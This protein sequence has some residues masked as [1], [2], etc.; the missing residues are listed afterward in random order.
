MYSFTAAAATDA[1][2]MRELNEDSYLVRDGLYLV[3]D[4][5]GGHDGGELA[6]AAV[7]ETFEQAYTETAQ[8]FELANLQEWLTQANRAAYDNGTGPAGNTP[9]SP[10]N[11]P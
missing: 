9:T 7:V 5:M 4:G 10:T 6:S 11:R 1:G 3:A 2:H 8:P